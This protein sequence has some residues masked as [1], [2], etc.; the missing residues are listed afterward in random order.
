[1]QSAKPTIYNHWRPSSDVLGFDVGTLHTGNDGEKRF[2][3]RGSVLAEPTS[4]ACKCGGS[5]LAAGGL[6]VCGKCCSVRGRFRLKVRDEGR[7]T[8]PSLRGEARRERGAA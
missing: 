3:K 2:D 6:L 1:M 4:R 7:G 8:G 5:M